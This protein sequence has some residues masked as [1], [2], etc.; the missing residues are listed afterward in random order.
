[1]WAV[2]ILSALAGFIRSAPAAS[3]IAGCTLA[4][5]LIDQSNYWV[6]NDPVRTLTA[7]GIA[8]TVGEV[9]LAV[10]PAFAIGRLARY[11]VR[12]LKRRRDL[13]RQLKL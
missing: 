5:L 7:A 11:G 6:P 12:Y 9:A 8:W 3:L 10:L 13:R 2:V 1:M 4:V